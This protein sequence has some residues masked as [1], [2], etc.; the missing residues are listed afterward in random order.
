ML[1]QPADLSLIVQLVDG[2]ELFER[3]EKIPASHVTEHLKV[4]AE[5]FVACRDLREFLITALLQKFIEKMRFLPD[6]MSTVD[7]SEKFEA[8]SIQNI[9]SLA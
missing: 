6:G 2:A 4:W 5:I 1:L 7:K 9:C 8:R 3:F